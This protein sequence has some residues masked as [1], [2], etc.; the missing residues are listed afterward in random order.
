MPDSSLVLLRPVEESDLEVCRQIDT[1]PGVTRPFNWPGFHDHRAH[2]RRWEEDGY[3]GGDSCMLA[4]AAPDD[5]CAGFVTWAPARAMGPSGGCIEFGIVLLPKYR[6]K[7]LGY[8]AQRLLA[9][10]LFATTFAHRLQA[11]TDVDNIAERRALE[12]AGFQLEGTLRGASFVEGHW[13]D[14][15]LYSKL[16][17]DPKQSVG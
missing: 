15:V 14:D 5:T 7:G 3:L 10:H 9:E 6:G 2:Q 4:V 17:E 1:D 8:A 16:R 12:R 13:R 11:S